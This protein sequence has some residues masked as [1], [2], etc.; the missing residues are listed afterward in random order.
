VWDIDNTIIET[1]KYKPLLPAIFGT[2]ADIGSVIIHTAGVTF[3][4]N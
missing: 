4:F 1:E 2:K 3:L